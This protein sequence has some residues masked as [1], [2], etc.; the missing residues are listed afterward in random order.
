MRSLVRKGTAVAGAAVVAAAVAG[1]A[2]F[3]A[4]A[5]AADREGNKGRAVGWQLKTGKQSTFW[6]G[7][8]LLDNGSAAFCLDFNLFGPKEGSDNGYKPEQAPTELG[9][10]TKAQL[11]YIAAQYGKLPDTTAG[12]NTTA[13]A[14]LLSWALADRDGVKEDGFNGEKLPWKSWLEK[15]MPH[16][17]VAGFGADAKVDTAPIVDE[18]NRL[19]A[20][21]ADIDAAPY[22]LTVPGSGKKYPYERIP[23]EKNLTVKVAQGKK[24]VPGVSINTTSLVNVAAP[25]APGTVGVT[26]DKGET[27]F[28]FTP[29]KPGTKAG[30]SFAADVTVNT[31]SFWATD[32]QVSG[33]PMQR[34]IFF[35][36][37]KK[38]LK[39]DGAIEFEPA[40][41]VIALKKD[42]ASGKEIDSPATYEIRANDA[43]GAE[44][45]PGGLVT[46]VTTG[47]GGKSAPVDLAAGTYWMVETK[48]PEGY[49]LDKKPTRF[50]VKAGEETVI[51]VFDSP[52]PKPPTTPPTAPP[53][54]PPTTP[55]ATTSPSTPPTVPPTTPPATPPSG[56][57]LAHTGADLTAP[58]AAAAAGLLL[59]GG[60]VLTVARRRKTAG[61]DES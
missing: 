29:D 45:K 21:V 14:S 30:A 58:L 60:G 4:P 36:A 10:D 40:S 2:L 56:D 53:T 51:T 11:A 15:G 9:A 26:N 47:K 38:T 57:E 17:A 44:G 55:P 49:E 43:S 61:S 1:P 6:G 37:E 32:K 41:I 5:V 12:R 19:R 3:S 34:L 33:K 18:F 48:A 59:V 28:A 24:P 13:A 16:G 27:T 20:E 42:R 22:T 23:A 52:L 50:E 39:V 46:T 54:T 35:A 7:T 25:K 31:P 8:H